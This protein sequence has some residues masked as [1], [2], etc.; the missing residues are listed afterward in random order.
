MHAGGKCSKTHEVNSWLQVTDEHFRGCQVS[1]SSGQ[2]SEGST[3]SLSLVSPVQL[4]L[5]ANESKVTANEAW[6]VCLFGI[7]YH[8][9]KLPSSEATSQDLFQIPLNASRDGDQPQQP[10]TSSDWK[11]DRSECPQRPV[12][13]RGWI[14]LLEQHLSYL[15][16]MQVIFQAWILISK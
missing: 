5:T 3:V 10:T 12:T 7:T 16:F 15:L 8:A 1:V 13:H 9:S 2:V 11:R 6:N 4:W 14:W